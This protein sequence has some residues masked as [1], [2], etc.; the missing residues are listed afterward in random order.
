MEFII[1]KAQAK[2]LPDIQILMDERTGN[3][4]KDGDME[5]RLN[6]INESP[7]NELYIYE[8]AQKIKG[9]MGFR[10]RENFD[11]ASRYG[12]ISALVTTAASQRNGVGRAMMEFAEELAKKHGSK[13]TWL[14]SDFGLEQDTHV[15]F[16]TG[17]RDH[18]ISLCKT[19][20]DSY[21]DN[22]KQFLTDNSKI[23]ITE[24]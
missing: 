8:R 9:L 2:D 4:M 13:G 6:M 22:P 5:G 17:I 7:I 21:Q 10:V 15:L 14:V 23:E 12:E 20:L 16:F 24:Q 11:E 18:G 1:R 3:T 19:V